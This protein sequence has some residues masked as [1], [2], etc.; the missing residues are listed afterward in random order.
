LTGEAALAF[1]AR[2]RGDG[3]ASIG[4]ALFLGKPG[5]LKRIAAAGEALPDGGGTFAELASSDRHLQVNGHRPSVNSKG[6]LAFM[7]GLR[8]ADGK[9]GVGLYV[10]DGQ[11]LRKVARTGETLA[12]ITV[13]DLGFNSVQSPGVRGFNNHCQAA[14]TITDGEGNYALLVANPCAERRAP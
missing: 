14:F 10:Y 9:P 6:Q 11:F 2:L 1:A 4:D 5:E 8:G 12:G 3:A 13:G 7:A